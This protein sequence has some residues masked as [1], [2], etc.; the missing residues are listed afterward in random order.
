MSQ[1]S[2]RD[3]LKKAGVG[4]AMSLVSMSFLEDALAKIAEL[5][6]VPVYTLHYC[7]SSAGQSMEKMLD[8]I[9]DF[10]PRSVG[11]QVPF[12]LETG[13]KHVFVLDN[14]TFFGYYQSL[15]PQQRYSYIELAELGVENYLCRGFPIINKNDAPFLQSIRRRNYDWTNIEIVD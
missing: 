1:I 9:R 5:N 4:T 15:Y 3:F 6:T 2:R 13:E 8:Y 10:D 7:P 14:D 12:S 11:G